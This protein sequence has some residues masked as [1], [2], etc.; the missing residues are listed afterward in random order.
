MNCVG[1]LLLLDSA[2]VFRRHFHRDFQRS[3]G[4]S[5]NTVVGSADVATAVGFEGF[6]E[7]AGEPFHLA[8]TA[9]KENI[10]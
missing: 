10:V 2:P 6:F 5:E 7:F 9:T 8:S 3:S 1:S 4:P